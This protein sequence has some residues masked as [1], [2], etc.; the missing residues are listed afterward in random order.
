MNAMETAKRTRVAQQT[1]AEADKYVL[2]QA[3]QVRAR[4]ITIHSLSNAAAGAS[5]VCS[6]PLRPRVCA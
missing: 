1:K 4:R 3:A 6:A 5:V 2:I